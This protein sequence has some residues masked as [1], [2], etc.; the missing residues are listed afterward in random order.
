MIKNT[1]SKAFLLILITQFTLSNVY[2][3]SYE[4]Y[5]EQRDNRNV[6]AVLY[7]VQDIRAVNDK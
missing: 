5:M 6:I 1:T 7:H 2:S 3:E 4:D